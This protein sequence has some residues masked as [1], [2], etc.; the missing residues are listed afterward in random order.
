VNPEI[1]ESTIEPSNKNIED[2]NILVH[3]TSE[4]FLSMTK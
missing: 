4:K 1:P 3:D 2:L